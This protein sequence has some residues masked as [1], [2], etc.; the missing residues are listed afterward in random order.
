MCD[1][2]PTSR[3]Q[4]SNSYDFANDNYFVFVGPQAFLCQ[5]FERRFAHRVASANISTRSLH[6]G[7]RYKGMQVTPMLDG[8]TEY[9]F[10][11]DHR[12]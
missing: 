6:S 8:F 7:D 3:S 4:A 11:L 10:Y 2:V 1:H 5:I 12:K 9:A